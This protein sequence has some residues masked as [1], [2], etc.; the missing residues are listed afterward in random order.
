MTL[1]LLGTAS[2]AD[3]SGTVWKYI[4]GKVQQKPMMDLNMFGIVARLWLNPAGLQAQSA[5]LAYMPDASTNH[6]AFTVT[7]PRLKTSDYLGT[8]RLT[9]LGKAGKTQELN[10]YRIDAGLFKGLLAVDGIAVSEKGRRAPVVMLVTRE[11]AAM[12]DDLF[13]FSK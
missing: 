12:D 2:A 7:L 5:D 3:L 4:Q 13:A 8:S 10:V 1:V 11:Y 6:W 9:P